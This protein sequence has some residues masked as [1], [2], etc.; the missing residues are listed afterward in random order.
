MKCADPCLADLGCPSKELIEISNETL[1]DLEYRNESSPPSRHEY[2]SPDQRAEWASDGPI[3]TTGNAGLFQEPEPHECQASGP[4]PAFPGPVPVP[5]LSHSGSRTK[6]SPS[7]Q[8]GGNGGGC[9]S[10]WTI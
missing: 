3:E 8:P 5:P 10:P 9:P 2:V 1:R 6:V 4:G 7:N